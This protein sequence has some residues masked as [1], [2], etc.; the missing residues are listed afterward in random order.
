MDS[1]SIKEIES[2]DVMISSLEIFVEFMSLAVMKVPGIRYTLT[3]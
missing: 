1:G 3:L 2:Q